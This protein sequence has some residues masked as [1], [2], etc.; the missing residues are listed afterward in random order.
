MPGT[1][2][3]EATRLIRAKESRLEGDGAGRRTP[4]WRFRFPGKAGRAFREGVSMG[5]LPGYGHGTFAEYARTEASA[6]R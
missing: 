4:I 6:D 1:D 2:G 3:Y 5:R